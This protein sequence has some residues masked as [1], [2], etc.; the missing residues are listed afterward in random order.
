MFSLLERFDQFAAAVFVHWIG[1]LLS[2][3]VSFLHVKQHV[4]I[5]PIK[6]SV[7]AD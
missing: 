4:C 7:V 1:S 6:D 5:V 2:S 3:D